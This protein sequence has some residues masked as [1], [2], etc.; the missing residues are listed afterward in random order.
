MNVRLSGRVLI[1]GLGIG[2]A[3]GVGVAKD[4]GDVVNIFSS[5]SLDIFS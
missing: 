3:T 1:V 5:C 4:V 2:Q